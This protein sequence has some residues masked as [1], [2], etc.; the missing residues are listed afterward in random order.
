MSVLVS[1]PPSPSNIAMPS[2]PTEYW[3]AVDGGGFLLCPGAVPPGAVCPPLSPSAPDAVPPLSPP[4]SPSVPD[5]VP[6]LLADAVPPPLS[7]ADP[8]PPPSPP[9]SLP[10]SLP[11]SDPP[12]LPDAVNAVS[13]HSPIEKQQKKKVVEY[14]VDHCENSACSFPWG[15][16]GLCSHQIVHTR[17]RNS[18]HIAPTYPYFDLNDSDSD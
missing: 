3:T 8:P 14:W 13:L 2:E 9:P 1:V 18:T 17:T 12:S 15:H 6:P 10:P 16:A 5:A 4:L 7:D 11:P